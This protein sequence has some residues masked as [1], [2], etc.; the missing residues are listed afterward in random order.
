[1]YLGRFGSS[2]SKAGYDRLISEWLSGGRRLPDGQDGLTVSE[3]IRAFWPHVE[4][5]YRRPDGT[6]TNEVGDY[7]LSLRPLRELYG[8]T[9]ARDFGR[10][11]LKA[12][13]QRMME[14]GLCRGVVNQRIGRIRRMFRWA[15]ENE[16]VPL[17]SYHGLLAVRGLERGRSEA[18]ET[19]PVKPV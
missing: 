16:L 7:K 9:S 13:R 1:H 15:T 11:A 6:P 19:E 14:A 3:L 10:L 2:A 5:H 4:T 17:S 12:V 8:S 18:R